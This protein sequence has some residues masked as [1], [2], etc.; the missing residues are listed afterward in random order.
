VSETKQTLKQK[1]AHEMREYLVMAFYLYC[2]VLALK[3]Y[4]K[5]GALL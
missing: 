4:L 1:A 3:T 2:C 5:R